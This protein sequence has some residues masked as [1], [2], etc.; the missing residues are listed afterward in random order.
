MLPIHV[1]YDSGLDE[2]EGTAVYAALDD[3]QSIMPRLRIENYGSEPWCVGE[4]SSADWYIQHT[5]IIRGKNGTLQLNADDLLDLVAR[6][7]WQFKNPHIDIVITSSDITAFDEGQQLNFVFGIASGRVSVQSIARYRDCSSFERFLAIK[8]VIWHELGHLFGMAAN[9]N[10]NHTEYKLGPHCT[11]P[12]C[13]MQQG[14]SVDEWVSH[15]KEVFQARRIY[16]PECLADV[17]ALAS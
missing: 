8:T 9:P 11:N 17:S 3:L 10:R 12:G 5:E 16:C 2:L 1:M 14:M 6:E 4:F 15:A 13:A 7:P